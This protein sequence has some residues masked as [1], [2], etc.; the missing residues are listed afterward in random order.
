MR[1]DVD[2]AP[3]EV[4]CRKSPSLRARQIR[5]VC[6]NNP[7]QVDQVLLGYKAHQHFN[8]AEDIWPRLHFMVVLD[9]LDHRRVPEG[10]CPRKILREPIKEVKE[11]L[12]ELSPTVLILQTKVRRFILLWICRRESDPLGR[13]YA[14]AAITS[15]GISKY[16][17][18]GGR[19]FPFSLLLLSQ[20]P[21]VHN[22][23]TGPS[24][25]R[26]RSIAP[27]LEELSEAG[28]K[29]LKERRIARV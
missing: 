27:S 18:G 28:S 7:V 13:W 24:C 19:L 10:A 12:P 6:E 15:Y 5:L 11:A 8:R 2:S 22:V 14:N 21:A 20:L 9:D 1:V 3:M 16:R 17:M 29:L 26:G 23:A 25:S 4:S